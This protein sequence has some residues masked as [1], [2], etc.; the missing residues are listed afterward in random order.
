MNAMSDQHNIEIAFAASWDRT[1]QFFIDIVATAGWEYQAPL[2]RL[3]EELRRRGYDRKFR[4]GRQL[5]TFIVSR[6]RVHGLRDDQPSLAFDLAPH[7]GLAIWQQAPYQ[8]AVEI[9]FDKVEI[10]SEVENLLSWLLAYP[11][12]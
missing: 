10:N 2:L 7:A 5:A 9:K 11:I 8:A 12:D 4:A 1:Q 6:S 3:I